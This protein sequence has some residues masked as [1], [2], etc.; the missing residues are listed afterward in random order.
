MAY[1]RY[2]VEFG[3]GVDLHGMDVTKAATKAVKDAISHGC[4]C[5]LNDIL[6]LKNPAEAM[7]VKVQVGTPFPEKV[8][9]AAVAKMVPFGETEV[10][11]REGGM[12][13]KGL[14]VKS[15]GDGDTM[16]MAIAVLTV[17]VDV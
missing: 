6:E 7:K 13:A 1:K 11:I 4:L 15:L 8:D 9:A 2:I 10:E 14:E 12:S 17:Y 16:V 5:G 3:M